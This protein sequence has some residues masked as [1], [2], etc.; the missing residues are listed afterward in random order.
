MTDPTRC[1]VVTIITDPNVVFVEIDV[2]VETDHD[3]RITTTR[4]AYYSDLVTTDDVNYA[5]KVVTE[6]A[7]YFK[8]IDKL[9][10]D[11]P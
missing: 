11:T 3:T 2:I 8:R 7:N 1:T 10:A 9:I 6:R 5:I 4:D